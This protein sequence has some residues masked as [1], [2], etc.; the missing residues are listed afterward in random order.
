MSNEMREVDKIGGR[1]FTN[2]MCR[3]KFGHK[4]RDESG[5]ISHIIIVPLFWHRYCGFGR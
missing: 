5:D 2:K 1:E 3:V 4:T